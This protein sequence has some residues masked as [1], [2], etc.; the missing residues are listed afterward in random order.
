MS[1]NKEK[2]MV[3]CQFEMGFGQEIMAVKEKGDR[4]RTVLSPH[5]S[6]ISATAGRH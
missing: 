4:N 5:I 6:E 1:H 2:K 3:Q